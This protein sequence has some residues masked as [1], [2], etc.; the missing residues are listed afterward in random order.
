MTALCA[1]RQVSWKT[2]CKWI[3]RDAEEGRRGLADRSRAPQHFPHKI[4]DAMAAPLCASRNRYD[5]WGARK[6]LTV[7]TARA[8]VGI[9]GLSH[10]SV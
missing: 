2:G 8:T 4:P 1:H 6:P 7:R 9:H 5:E 10:L 3:A